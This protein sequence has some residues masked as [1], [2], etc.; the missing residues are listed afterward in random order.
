MI[1]SNLP[2]SRWDKIFCAATVR[3]L[4]TRRFGPLPEAVETRLQNASIDELE[5]L[6]DHLLDA[7]S[8][9]ALFPELP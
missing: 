3:R 6:T 8:L 7:P 4:L 1:T 5:S 9:Q 2:F